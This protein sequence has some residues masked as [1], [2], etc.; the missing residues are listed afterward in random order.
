MRKTKRYCDAS[1]V[2]RRVKQ[3]EKSDEIASDT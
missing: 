1:L 2:H 3:G